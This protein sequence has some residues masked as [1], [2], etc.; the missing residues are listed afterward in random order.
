MPAINIKGKRLAFGAAG[1]GTSVVALHSSASSGSQ[2][3]SFTEHAPEEFCVFTPDLAGYGGSDAWPGGPSASLSHEADFIHGLIRAWEEPVHLVGHSFGGAVAVQIAMTYPK[4]VKSLTVIEPTIF[5]LL[6][7][8]GP[9]D[10][11]LFSEMEA[12]RGTL[13]AAA[14]LGNPNAGMQKFVDFW[15]G[16]GAWAHSHAKL[17]AHLSGQIGQVINNF[18]AGDAMLWPLAACRQIACPTLA[19]MGTEGPAPALRVTEMLAETIP[20][21]KLQII[22]GAGHMV[23]LSDPHIVDPMIAAHIRD[24][25]TR[26]TRINVS[27][28]PQAA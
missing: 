14:A 3:K 8:G 5:H 21:A 24:A 26:S 11:R 18:A 10:R 25:E 4:W 17:K 1:T 6:R 22:A 23:P 15:N 7:D 20:G 16:E 13:N 27:Y 9:A 19:I 12:V 28:L 2:W